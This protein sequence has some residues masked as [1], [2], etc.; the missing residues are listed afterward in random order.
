M[1]RFLVEIQGYQSGDGDFPELTADY[2]REALE[3]HLGRHDSEGTVT[4]RCRTSGDVKYALVSMRLES[5][6]T[7]KSYLPDN[8]R[9]VDFLDRDPGSS[10]GLL[11]RGPCVVIEGRDRAG[12]TLDD[13]V[14]PRLRSGLI[15]VQEIDQE[16]RLRLVERNARI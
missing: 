15:S 1:T 10:K 2:V 8:Y 12:W 11:T 6:E 16:E 13:Y 9:I 4:V 7:V 14:M 3:E 5:V